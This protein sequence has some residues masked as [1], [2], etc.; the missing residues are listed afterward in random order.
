MLRDNNA[1][2]NNHLMRNNNVMHNNHLMRDNHVMREK[3][4]RDAH[5]LNIYNNSQETYLQTMPEGARVGK[6]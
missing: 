6:D 5:K 4:D 1:M 2:R 3:Q